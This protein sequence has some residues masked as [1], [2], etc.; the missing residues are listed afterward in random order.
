MGYL[1][2]FGFAKANL[3]SPLMIN[4]RQS[5][6]SYSEKHIF[7]KSHIRRGFTLS[8]NARVLSVRTANAAGAMFALVN[9]KH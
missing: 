6:I 3:E 1:R 7:D 4:L 9:I 8:G 5:L 2:L